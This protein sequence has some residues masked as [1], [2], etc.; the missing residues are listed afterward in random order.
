MEF[1]TGTTRGNRCA[2]DRGHMDIVTCLYR[3]SVIA[4]D[5]EFGTLLLL[6]LTQMHA[7][8]DDQHSP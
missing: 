6:I 3:E 2:L 8:D 4:T 7:R 1:G 5:M